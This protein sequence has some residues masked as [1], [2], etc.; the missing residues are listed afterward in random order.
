MELIFAVDE[1][2]NIGYQGEMLFRIS[3]DLNRFKDLTT[4]HILI[5]GRRT[6]EALPGCKPLPNRI[7]IVLTSNEAY[8]VGNGYLVSSIGE[9]DQLLEKINGDKIKKEFLIGGGNLVDQLIDRCTYGHITK[10]L[11]AF[12]DYDTSLYNLDRD[13]RWKVLGES[14]VY[15]DGSVNY[16]Y[17]DYERDE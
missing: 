13:P 8:D 2:W 17:V 3:K 9:L 10:V 7:N 6:F 15:Q 5:M 4:G 11:K 16:R 14:P 12:T 1:N